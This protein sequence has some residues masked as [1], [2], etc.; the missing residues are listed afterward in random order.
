[1]HCSPPTAI[2]TFGPAAASEPAQPSTSKA[3]ARATP[4]MRRDRV[5]ARTAMVGMGF[6]RIF[7]TPPTIQ[8]LGPEV[9]PGAW[10]TTN[11]TARP[12][13]PRADDVRIWAEAKG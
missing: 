12:A 11:A 4:P 5:S 1:M 3:A 2:V 6:L 8:S 9:E 10:P 7:S 13:L